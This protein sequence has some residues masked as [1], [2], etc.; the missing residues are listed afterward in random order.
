MKEMI[1]SITL[2][3]LFRFC[4]TVGAA[5]EFAMG[6]IVAGSVCVLLFLFTTWLEQQR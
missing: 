1:L 2:G 3:S 6:N 4:Y 5:Y